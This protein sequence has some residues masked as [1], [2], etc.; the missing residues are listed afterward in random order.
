VLEYG[1]V[2][3]TTFLLL[4]NTCFYR[5][6]K[7]AEIYYLKYTGVLIGS[8]FVSFAFYFLSS[9]CIAI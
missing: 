7:I 8:V 2:G 9:S 5:S 3:P 6:E 1:G 4:S